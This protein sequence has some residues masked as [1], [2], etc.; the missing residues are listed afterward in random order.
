M[1]T[2]SVYL[3]ELP[4]ILRI[5]KSKEVP[6]KI[7]NH[8]GQW[9]E[10]YFGVLEVKDIKDKSYDI[11]VLILFDPETSESTAIDV[12][13]IHTIELKSSVEIHGRQVTRVKILK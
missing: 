12:K 6:V 11:T 1:E 13:S 5:I 2:N 8:S 10:H 9:S 3:K 7:Y 4:A